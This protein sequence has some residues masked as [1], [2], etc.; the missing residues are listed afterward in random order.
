MD[1]ND[2]N[3]DP[4]NDPSM[5]LTQDSSSDTYDPTAQ[6]SGANFVS[7]VNTYLGAGLSVVSAVAA[8]K[9]ILQPVTLSPTGPPPYAPPVLG[10]MNGRPS[11]LDR[12]A[13]AFKTSKTV[14][15]AVASGLLL[16]VLALLWLAFGGHKKKAEA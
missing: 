7:Q 1:P 3:Y 2:P 15:V 8:A 4:Y 13:A 11:L 12:A 16:V 10:W 5:T 6:D 9:Q 14:V